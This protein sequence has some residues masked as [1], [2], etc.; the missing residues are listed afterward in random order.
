MAV[1]RALDPRDDPPTRE[2]ILEVALELFA[3]KGYDATAT[4]EITGRLGISPGAFY[5][6]FPT[7]D[8]CLS[9]LVEPYLE[10]VEALI[11]E[12][13]TPLTTPDEAR[14]LLSAYQGLLLRRREV[15]VFLDRE[16]TLAAHPELG[17]RLRAVAD[18]LR[19]L[20]AGPDPTEVDHIRAAAALG[21]VRRPTLRLRETSRKRLAVAVDAALAALLA[22]TGPADPT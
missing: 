20:L 4:R 13:P 19:G 5:Y 6:H 22:P 10:E 3:A 8:H 21:A 17:D 18:D 11:A 1:V 12:Q 2:R 14:T 9:A 16:P 15:A 7:K